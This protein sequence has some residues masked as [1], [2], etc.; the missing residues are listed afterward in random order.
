M[1][2]PDETLSQTVDRFAVEVAE[3]S[4]RTVWRWLSGKTAVPL[5]IV[6]KIHTLLND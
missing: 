2:L 3:V 5:S 4:P 1:Q 6:Q